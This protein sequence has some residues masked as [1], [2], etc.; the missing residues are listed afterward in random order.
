MG[1]EE[2][3]EAASIAF[4]GV[5]IPAGMAYLVGSI[6][7]Q[8]RRRNMVEDAERKSGEGPQP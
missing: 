5:M 4:L 6:Q 3:M 2:A 8:E 1:P 7:T